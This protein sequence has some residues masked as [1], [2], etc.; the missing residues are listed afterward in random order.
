GDVLGAAQS[1]TSSSLA[2][3]RVLADRDVIA[4]ARAHAVELL[5]HDPGLVTIPGLAAAVD[6]IEASGLGDFIERS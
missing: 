6:R 5:E 2:N 4:R 3:L 1:G